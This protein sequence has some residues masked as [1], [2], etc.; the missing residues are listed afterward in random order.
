MARLFGMIGNRPD[1]GAR[2]LAVEAE[3][4]RARSLAGGAS[5]LA[6]RTAQLVKSFGTAAAPVHAL[7]GIVDMFSCA[8]NSLRARCGWIADHAAGIRQAALPRLARDDAMGPHA[9]PAPRARRGGG[10]DLA[11]VRRR[12]RTRDRTFA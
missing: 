1:L 11:Q 5:P 10:D 12:V 3:A 2:V 7:R 6:I 4:L 8:G 9:A